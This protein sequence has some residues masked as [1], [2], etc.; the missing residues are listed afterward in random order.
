MTT[1]PCEK[2]IPGCQHGGL[3]LAFRS[4]QIWYVASF[5]A[6][7]ENHL[8]GPLMLFIGVVGRVEMNLYIA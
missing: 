2:G 4:N 7:P 6:G 5:S 1:G 8:D 3:S